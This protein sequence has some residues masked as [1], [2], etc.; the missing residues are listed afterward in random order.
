MYALSSSNG[1]NSTNSPCSISRPPVTVKDCQSNFP[2]FHCAES[3]K[4][5]V[6]FPLKCSS[7][8][9]CWPKFSNWWNNCETFNSAPCTE[10]LT[11]MSFWAN[12]R[13][14]ETPNCPSIVESVKCLSLS[15]PG[16]KSRIPRSSEAL[17]LAIWTSGISITILPDK[18]KICS[19]E[20]ILWA[21]GESAPLSA[22]EISICTSPFERT[23]RSS[24][25]G[26][27]R[28]RLP[29]IPLK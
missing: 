29:L 13:S 3:L 2:A 19:S 20:R 14:P 12:W 6:S 17:K 11:V 8:M 22:S 23:F 1:S 5:V 21:A 10:V 24:A 25:S 27:A 15:F 28:W 9:N 18:L 26:W 16:N 4:S 7:L